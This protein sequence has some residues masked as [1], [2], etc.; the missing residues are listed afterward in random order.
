M[1]ERS[2]FAIWMIILGLSLGPAISNGFARFAYGLILPAMRTDLAWNFT[3]AGWINTANAIGYLIGAMLA[4]SLVNRTGPRALFIWGFAL[5]TITL[6]LSATTR[7]L[8]ML[9]LWRMLAGIGGAP[10][11]IAG[12]VIASGLFADDKSRNAL[13][14]GVYFGGGGLG[15]LLTAVSIP[16]FMDW[17]GDPGWPLVW[18]ALGVATFVAFLPAWL[19]AEAISEPASRAAEAQAQPLPVL[20]MLPALACYFLFGLGYLIY[21]TFL[22]AWMR[23][24]GAG[25]ATVSLTWAIMG[26]GVMLSPFIWQR[27][28]ARAQGGRAMF[29]TSLAIAVG[30]LLPIAVDHPAGPLVSAA[31][32]GGTFFMVPSSVTTFSRKNLPPAQWGRAVSLF[33]VI[34]SIGQI[35]GPVGAGAISDITGG[36]TMGLAISGAILFCGALIGAVQAPLVT[37]DAA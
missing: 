25:T 12:G 15:M 34:F 35:I 29:Q 5:T 2:S 26:V 9:S 28:L 33:T 11:F 3:E 14:I 4:L 30:I 24:T 13:A 27:V 18:M 7:D 22:I 37:G 31:I 23:A 32:V 17:F 8:W 20:A 16:Q 6:A 19:A 1:A 36:T 21:I 10:V